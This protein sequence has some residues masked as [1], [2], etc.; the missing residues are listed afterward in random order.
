[1]S[2]SSHVALSS[3]GE[4]AGYV[5]RTGVPRPSKYPVNEAMIG[6]WCDAVG[7]DNPAYQDPVWAA[8]SR[9][10]GIIAPATTMNMWTLPGFR[11]IHEVGEPLDVVT[12]TL[13]QAGYTSVAAVQ[14]DH[15]YK[16]PLRPGD[17]LLQVQHLGWISGR[18]RTALGAGHFFD[19]VSDFVTT[20]GENVGRATMRIFKWA[21]EGGSEASSPREQAVLARPRT[22]APVVT[23]TVPRQT[24][25]DLRPGTT[26]PS[27]SMPLTATR[28][29]ALA[30]ATMDFNDVHFEQRAAVAAGA[31]DIYLNILGSAGLLNRYLTDWAGPE[32]ELNGI[33][34]TLRNQNH[35]GDVVSFSGTVAEVR[36]S[37]EADRVQVEIDVKAENERGLNQETRVTMEI[38]N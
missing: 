31:P 26:L 1:M 35:P 14:N 9:W 2:G 17:R 29:T 6:L 36:S 4:L 15:V 33:R 10:R 12:Q 38:G 19:I 30:A 24:G 3:V 23:S 27:W 20:D 37:G 7:D 21:P 16:R 22:G 8:G 18:K 11:R 34:L 25:D 28:I 32:A 5:G 13:N